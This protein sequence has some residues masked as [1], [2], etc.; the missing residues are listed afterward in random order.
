MSLSYDEMKLKLIQACDSYYN[1]SFSF[2]TDKEFDDLKDAFKEQYPDDPFLKTIGAPVPE[3]S[4]WSKVKHSIPMCSCNKVK[5][6]DEF[7]DWCA[8][9][10]FDADT[11]LITSEK[12]DGMSLSIDYI[13]GKLVNGI[14]RGDGF[15]GEAIT[16]N[17]IKMQNVKVNLD[18]KYT[19]SLRGEVLLNKNDFKAVNL[20]CEAR[21]E[22][23]FQNIRN[24]ASG[25]AKRYDSKY[26][27]YLYVRYYYASGDFKT[28]SEMYQFIESL[29]LKTCKHFSGNFETSKIVYNEYE[30]SIRAG[31]D[32]AIDG[33]VIEPD[34][35]ETLNDLGMLNE[36][37][38]G[39]IAWKFTSETAMTKIKDIVWQLGN[40]SRITPVAIL[41]TV[42]L[43]G[44]NI[45]RATMHN[46][47]IFEKLKPYKG[48][49]CLIS[50][51]GDVIPFIEK[52]YP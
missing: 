39:Q 2:I 35:I 52:V 20:I 50:R 41:E 3:A 10:R 29:G 46:L 45:S 44:V 4:D 16:Q 32:H 9:N 6:V 13:N 42:E 11:A 5:T 21:G 43:N 8:S 23:G 14:T 30:Q 22:K 28:K 25:I 34:N 37:L 1:K 49:T 26:S 24:G 51:R 7:I 12:L 40:S 36:N 48:A 47:D 19:G 15:I 31:L 33:L 18:N 38:R 17:V 27:E